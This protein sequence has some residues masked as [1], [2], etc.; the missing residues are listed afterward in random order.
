LNKSRAFNPASAS[1]ARDN[2]QEDHDSNVDKEEVNFFKPCINLRSKQGSHVGKMQQFLQHT[3]EKLI[4][5]NQIFMW[6]DENVLKKQKLKKE[7]QTLAICEGKW[8][9]VIDAFSTLFL[10]EGPGYERESFLSIKAGASGRIARFQ[11]TLTSIRGTDTSRRS[12]NMMQDNPALL[13][14]IHRSN[15]LNDCINVFSENMANHPFGGLRVRFEG[16]EGTGP[17]VTR[18]LFAAFANALKSGEKYKHWPTE[19]FTEC[20][21]LPTQK[22]VFSPKVGKY[23]L[24]ES[25][26]IFEHPMTQEKRYTAFVAIGRFLG[27]TLWFNQTIPLI[28]SRPILL[29]LLGKENEIS[30]D[31]FAFYDSSMYKS[32]SQLLVDA[33][34]NE[35]GN[36]E[37][38]DRYNL[39][40]E[41]TVDGHTEPLVPN[42]QNL[43]VSKQ[44]ALQFVRLFAHHKMIGCRENELQGLKDGLHQMIPK[45]LLDSLEAEDF[46]LLLSGGVEEISYQ[47]LRSIITFSNSRGCSRQL[48][49]RYK[50]WF[51]RILQKMSPSERQKLLYFATGSS[52]LPALDNR[53]GNNEELSITVDIINNANS[54][55][56]PMSSTCGQRISMPLYPSK[57]VLRSKL[58]QAI[59][60][61]TYGLG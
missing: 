19:F 56:L 49:E 28:L 3:D 1:S 40:F 18:G 8:G 5:A 46:Q 22:G 25:N 10:S 53:V 21:N 61:Q 60:C 35:C 32:F 27:L 16:E 12:Y 38:I 30:F 44:N 26:F 2:L 31:D 48:L 17:G 4:T 9:R 37:F 52:V 57:S 6:L 41:V 51:W 36:D 14:N 24:Q 13:I 7:S 54:A 45:E 43:R 15:L 11:R 47:R 58:L 55:A 42:G 34:S 20:G 59:E 29:Y 39:C 50:S 33:M 23:L